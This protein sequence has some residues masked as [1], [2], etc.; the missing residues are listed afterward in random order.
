MDE[1]LRRRNTDMSPARR[2][3]GLEGDTCLDDN[4][5]NFSGVFFALT[6]SSSTEHV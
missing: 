5:D 4:P 6:L 2:G 3:S 1:R